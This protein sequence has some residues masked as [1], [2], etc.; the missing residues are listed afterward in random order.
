MIYIKSISRKPLLFE[1][2]FS[3]VASLFSDLA[4]SFE[5]ISIIIIQIKTKEGGIIFNMIHDNSCLTKI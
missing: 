4:S 1:H 3:G 2:N 5:E